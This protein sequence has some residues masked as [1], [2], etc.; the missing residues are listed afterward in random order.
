MRRHRQ[1]RRTP[2]RKRLYMRATAVVLSEQGE[3][4]LVK[5]RGQNAWA[6]PG[7]RMIAGEDPARRA[8]LEVAEETGLRITAPSHIGRYAGGVASHEVYLAYASGEPR[9]DR[10]EVQDAMWWDTIRPLEVQQHV[11]AILTMVPEPTPEE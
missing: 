1:S 4:L 9:A 8:V 6:L 11:R 3:V 7:G 10:K 2:Q 5:H